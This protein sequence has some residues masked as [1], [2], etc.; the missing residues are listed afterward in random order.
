[1]SVKNNRRVERL[2][3]LPHRRHG[4]IRPRP[5][6]NTIWIHKILHR[7]AF[8]QKF[9]ITND[10]KTAIRLAVT[11]DRLRDFLAGLDRYGA[12]VDYNLIGGCCISDVAGDS[13][14]KA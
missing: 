3:N 2:V 10:I 14:D 9:W 4:F 1:M 8:A 13:L 6:H 11:L 5:N 7:K 12:L